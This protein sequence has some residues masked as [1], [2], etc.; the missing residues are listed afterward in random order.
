VLLVDMGAPP[1]R[2]RRSPEMMSPFQIG[3]WRSTSGL[4]EAGCNSCNAS[5]RLASAL[6]ILL[7][8]QKSAEYSALRARA[9]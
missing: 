1:A 9:G 8:K 3:I 6:S 5:I 7:R 4:R 2:D